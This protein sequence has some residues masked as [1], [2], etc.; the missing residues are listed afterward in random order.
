MWILSLPW[1]MLGNHK[2]GHHGIRTSSS[3]ILWFNTPTS[4]GQLYNQWSSELRDRTSLLHVKWTSDD[5]TIFQ[6]NK[7]MNSLGLCSN[8]LFKADRMKDLEIQSMD[9]QAAGTVGKANSVI[10]DTCTCGFHRQNANNKSRKMATCRGSITRT[11]FVSA[12]TSCRITGRT[13]HNR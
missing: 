3:T 1:P 12:C 13:K 2:V 6:S 10:Y 7:V 9:I 11:R 8:E 4:S 5:S